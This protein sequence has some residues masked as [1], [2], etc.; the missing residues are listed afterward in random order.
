VASN[1]TVKNRGEIMKLKPFVGPKSLCTCGHTGD[2]ENS[3]HQTLYEVAPGK[4]K[5]T[6]NNCFCDRFTWARFTKKYQ[7]YIKLGA[8]HADSSGT[9]KE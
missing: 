3:E 5:C 7:N 8:E 4:G 2:G 1:R 6:I 9:K